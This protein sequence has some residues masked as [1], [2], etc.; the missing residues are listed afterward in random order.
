MQ[1]DMP[2]GF[3]LMTLVLMRH[4]AALRELDGNQK[5]LVELL[6]ILT[7]ELWV[8]HAAVHKPEVFGP[9]LQKVLGA[10]DAAKVAE[11]AAGPLKKLL[12]DNTDQAFKDDAFGLPWMVCTNPKGEKENFW[13]VDHLGQVTAFLG[14]E[15]PSARGWQALL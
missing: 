14:L 10:A 8:N 3:P 9:I 1:T 2:D 12:N 11:A 6:D 13:G 5:R 7:R 4:L 15:K